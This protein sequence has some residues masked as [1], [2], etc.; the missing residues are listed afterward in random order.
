MVKLDKVPGIKKNPPSEE[1]IQNESLDVTERVYALDDEQLDIAWDAEVGSW[2]ELNMNP[3]QNIMVDM[4]HLKFRF[5]TLFEFCRDKLEIDVE[6]F[7]RTVK[8][9]MLI[10]MINLRHQFQR[11]MLHARLTEGIHT[12]VPQSPV[13]LPPGQRT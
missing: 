10:T 1:E 4:F 5:D 2:L 9:N 7:D 13:I 3:A 8:R 11:Q 12:P 6:E